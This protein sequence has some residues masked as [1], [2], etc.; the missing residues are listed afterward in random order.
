MTPVVE[1]NVLKPIFDENKYRSLILSNKLRVLLISDDRAEISGG[2]LSVFVGHQHDPE[3][4]NGLAHFLEHMLFLG[5]EKYP[6]PFEF[7]NYVKQNGGNMNAHTD[8]HETSYYFDVNSESLEGVLDRFSGFFVCPLFDTTYVEREVNAVNSEHEMNLLYDL[9]IKYHIISSSARSGHPVSKFGTGSLQTLKTEPE[10]K[11]IDVIKELKEFHNKYYCSGIMHLTLIS[12]HSLDTLQEYAT[13]YFSDITNKG[14]SIQNY[15]EEF[16][17]EK[18]YL[19]IKDSPKDGSLG[20][21][22]YVV[23]NKNERSI[24]FNYQFPDIRRYKRESPELYFLEILGHEGHGSL[25]SILKRDGLCYSLSSGLNEMFSA[26]LF[27]IT[28]KL[29]EKGYLEINRVIEYTLNYVNLMVEKDI[30]MN[31]ISDIVRLKQVIFDYKNRPS[32][33]ELISRSSFLVANEVPLNEV[34]TYGNRIERIDIE[35]VGM[36]KKYF[37]PDNMFIMFSFP[38]N[39]AM[40]EDKRYAGELI[41]DRHYKMNYLKQEFYPEIK[42][43][44]G[45]VSVDYS[46]KLG[47]ELPKR[48]EYIPESFDIVN[49]QN[50]EISTFPELVD[51]SR[52]QFSRRV[53]AYFKPDT[54]FS[55]PHGFTQLFFYSTKETT[56]ETLVL[57]HLA[58]LTITKIIAE[59]AYS[60]TLA[61]LDCKI[62]GGFSLS[63]S[64]DS[65]SI[66]LSGFNDKTGNLLQFIM[67]SIIDLKND[68][69]SKYISFFNEAVEETKEKVENSLYNPSRLVQLTLYNFKEFYS[70]YTPSKEDILKTVNSIDYRKLCTYISDFFS[71]C[72]IKSIILGNFDIN[73]VY[74]LL[75]IVLTEQLLGSNYNIAGNTDKL[76]LRSCVDVESSIDN[77]KVINSN[78]L[79]FSKPVLN[80]ID[81]NGAV[82]YTI[83][84]G[85]YNL[86]DM[87][88]LDLISKYL[89]VKCFHELRTNQQLG[90]I[91]RCSSFNLKPAI[92]ISI[93]V[94]SPEYSNTL[95]INKIDRVLQK[96]LNG[97]EQSMSEEEFS[98]YVESEIRIYSNKP[99]NLE[100]EMDAYLVALTNGDCEFD[101]KQKAIRILEKLNY[102]EF[103]AFVEVIIKRPRIIVQSIS[104]F[105]S[106]KNSEGLEVEYISNNYLKVDEFSHFKNSK[107]TKMFSILA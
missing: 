107:E 24:T 85:K 90:Y 58:S 87:I 68:L 81:K 23:P 83:D 99:K 82:V 46:S 105:E 104:I 29:T 1:N 12:N 17:T 96:L 6:D 8:Y 44:I 78:N 70:N 3:N 51:M 5:S 59:E 50:K 73:K 53:E 71:S 41:Y 106:K 26:N 102:S 65:I 56:C 61:N 54:T 69:G 72:I 66:T 101:W 57:D 22:I 42:N 9:F 7:D 38:E 88:L 21:V 27:E 28:I 62:I 67:E 103:K 36:L 98:S 20:S 25:T 55:T 39:K 100:E 93:I 75:N 64:F 30:D 45:N 74:D 2:V 32:I 18:P 97:I 11:G 84:M 13:K 37:S 19:S 15:F 49:A 95:V 86:R 48:N 52:N 35:A 91:V 92:G 76:V 16:E 34:L 89:D 33:E 94:Q 31:I 60:A 43:I 63:N 77:D 47:F 14:A 40:I 4:L 80:P 10:E 79:I